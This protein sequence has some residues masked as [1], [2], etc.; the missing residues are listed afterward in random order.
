ME[1]KVKKIFPL[2]E[3]VAFIE[4]AMVS[5]GWDKSRLTKESGASSAAVTRFFQ[6]GM[7][8]SLN[9]MKIMAALDLIKTGTASCPVGCDQ[10]MSDI[11]KDVKELIESGKHWGASLDAN[12]KSF[13]AGFDNDKELKRLSAEMKTL[14]QA[15][16]AGRNTDTDAVASSNIGKQGT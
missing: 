11:C 12:I 5:R 1:N 16:L 9:T 4:S 7:I 8:N 3:W 10:K 2:M 15:M 13:K 14:R 6:D